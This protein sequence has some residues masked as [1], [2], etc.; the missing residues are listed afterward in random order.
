MS[1]RDGVGEMMQ[2]L[3]C[4]GDHVNEAGIDARIESVDYQTVVIAGK[5]FMFC[6]IRMKGGFVVVG[7]PSS[8]IDP[9][10]WRDEIARKIAYGNT[11]DRVWPLE[12]YRKTCTAGMGRTTLA[13]RMTYPDY[14]RF[15]IGNPE[16]QTADVDYTNG[17]DKGYH[18]IHQRG[19]PDERHEWC[20]ADEYE[21]LHP[22]AR[23]VS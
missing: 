11:Y 17:S 12:A 1:S 9:G 14:E 7:E 18:V 21:Q 3:G 22:L 10:N 2:E 19:T 8:C 6:G 4:D 16:L 5:K 20:P 13:E 23:V 15:R